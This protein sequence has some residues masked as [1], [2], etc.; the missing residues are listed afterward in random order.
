MKLGSPNQRIR[1]R[2]ISIWLNINSLSTVH[3]MDRGPQTKSKMTKGNMDKIPNTL[4]NDMH[5][6]IKIQEVSNQ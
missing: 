1:R 6:S 2:P 5:P 3:S 4:Q